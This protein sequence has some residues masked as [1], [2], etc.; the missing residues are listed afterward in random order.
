MPSP[1]RIGSIWGCDMPVLAYKLRH[2]ITL[3]RF[4]K[5]QDP[6]TGLISEEWVDDAT[7]WASVE[8][9]SGRDFIAARAQQSEISSRV[10][11]RYRPDVDSTMRLVHRGRIYSIEGPPLPDAKS[12]LEYLTLM[13]AAGVEHA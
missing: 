3:Q 9:L 2:R 13:V 5:T 12:G 6:T 4:V 11:I 10:V 1:G 7:V 8:P